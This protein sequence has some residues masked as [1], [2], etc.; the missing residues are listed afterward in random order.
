MAPTAGRDVQKSGSDAA[1]RV[2]ARPTSAGKELQVAASA[3]STS[4][5][6][7]NSTMQPGGAKRAS[8]GS[9]SEDEGSLPLIGFK[10]SVIGYNREGVRW[11][12]GAWVFA[13]KK[14]CT[15]R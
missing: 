6:S 8:S 12:V 13:S 15:G 14:D 1:V 9:W 4:H 2:Q 11:L 7:G 5:A 3:S 10:Y